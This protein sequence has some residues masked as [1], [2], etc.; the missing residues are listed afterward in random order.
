MLWTE[1]RRVA[2]LYVAL[3]T[4]KVGA[5]THSRSQGKEPISRKAYRA[6]IIDHNMKYV[7]GKKPTNNPKSKGKDKGEGAQGRNQAKVQHQNA[8]G[9]PRGPEKTTK[10]ATQS[11]TEGQQKEEPQ[12]AGRQREGATAGEKP[13]R[14]QPKVGTHPQRAT[15]ATIESSEKP[16]SLG[17]N[18]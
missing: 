14:G 6:F 3:V 17:G 2:K 11:G 8:E 7:N 9:C 15:R 1:R 18:A 13:K 12:G 10:R 4:H 5:L 16:R